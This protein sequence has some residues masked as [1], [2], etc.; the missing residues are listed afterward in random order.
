MWV[1]KDEVIDRTSDWLS[2]DPHQSLDKYGQR[3]QYYLFG[4]VYNILMFDFI[5]P[6]EKRCPL[7]GLWCLSFLGLTTV[8]LV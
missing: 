3:D 2:T 4:L 7:Y 6:G 8:S 5:S 1:L